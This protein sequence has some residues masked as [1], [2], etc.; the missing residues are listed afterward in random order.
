MLKLFKRKSKMELLED[1]YEKL[2]EQ[3]YKMMSYNRRES[4][5]LQAEANEIFQQMVKLKASA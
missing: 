2:M 3:S 5:R 4:D 1:K